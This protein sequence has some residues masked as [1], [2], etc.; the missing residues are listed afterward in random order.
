[1][2]LGKPPGKAALTA[3]V[4][5][6]EMDLA[7]LI[8]QIETEAQIMLQLANQARKLLPKKV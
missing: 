1:M 4:M 5:V 2:V 7:R 3:K 6:P 8:D